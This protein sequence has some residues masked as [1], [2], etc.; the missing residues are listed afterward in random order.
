MTP[1]IEN[2]AKSVKVTRYLECRT[3]LCDLFAAISAELKKY[4]YRRFAEDL[5]FGP[6]NYLHLILKGTR[7]VSVKAAQRIAEHVHL[8]GIDKQYFVNLAR[9]GNAK[10]NVEREQIFSILVDLKSRELSSELDRDSLEYLSEWYYPVIRELLGLPGAQGTVEW[11]IDRL[12]PHLTPEQVRKS[13]ELLERTGHIKWN[14]TRKAF[15]LAQTHVRT[16]AEVRGIAIVRY[17]NEMLARAAE[18]ITK[19]AAERRDI[20]ALTIQV[21]DEGAQ[22]IKLELQNFRKKILEL[23]EKY[24]DADQIYQLNFQF[25]P[26][27]KEK[28]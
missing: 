3:F 1:A 9:H 19:V 18:A 4:T 11:I 7:R 20:S 2:I 25:F 15:S 14:K 28:A 21:S 10:S 26:F 17:H 23:S 12:V 5:G 16:P 8:R 24:K 6:T 13:L 27:T 22:E